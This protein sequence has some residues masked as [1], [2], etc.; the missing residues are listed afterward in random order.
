[1]KKLLAVFL[2]LILFSISSYSQT[3][4][5]SVH[6]ANG[7]VVHAAG[8]G[9]SYFISY[10]GGAN[11]GSYPQGSDNYN[12]VFA[13][14]SRVVL[15]GDGGVVRVSTNGGNSFT[16]YNL[17][18][19]DLNSVWFADDNTGWAVGNSGR[20]VKTVNGGVNW[21]LQTAPS[22]DN[23][24]GV[25]FTSTSNGYA[26]GDNG[27]VIYTVNGGTNWLSYT[28][29]SSFKLTAIDVNGS[30]IIATGVDSKILKYNGS[31][32]STIDYKIVTK[33]DVRGVSMINSTTF[34]TC[35]GGGFVNKTTDG[36]ATR[37]YQQNPMM[38][39]LSDIFFY[40][41]NTGWAVA[42]NTKAIIRTADGGATWQFQGGVTVNTNWVLKQTG[43]TGAGIGNGFCYHPTNR[44]GMFCMIGN[45]VYRSL[46]KGETWTTVGVDPPSP[47]T[48]NCHSFYVN[49]QDTNLWI[50]SK[51]SGGGY[52]IASSNYGASWYAVA[53]PLTLTSYGMPLEVD[54]NSPNTV[55]LAPDGA[56]MRIS[57]NWGAN[58]TNLSGGEPGGIFRSPCDI[59][60]QYENSN[61]IIVGDGTTGTGSGK[62]WKST[63][64]GINWTLINTVSG[65]EI[66]MIANS[67]VDL[68]LMYHSTWSTGSFWK[69]TN[70]GSN[71]F[72]T[73][74]GGIN[75][76]WAADVAKDDPNS[77][78]YGTYST[79]TW[80]STNGGVTFVAKSIGGGSGAG[81][82]YF[83]K[84]TLLFSQTNRG[85]Y[86]LDISYVVTPVTGV[87][88]TSGEIPNSF[89]LSQN[90]PNPFNPTTQIKFDVAKSSDVSI[91]VYDVIGNEVA[92]LTSG[93]HQ[94][95]KYTADFN[96]SNLATGIYFYSLIVDGAK[97][98]TKKMILVK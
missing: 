23:L 21:T 44:N 5:N 88:Q 26:C 50:A 51:G 62:V 57:T 3:G 64:G 36:G 28:T 56:A 58:W 2:G 31:I 95:G 78:A 43:A 18:G 25:R 45:T 89:M 52:V 7:T 63:N 74:N 40:D 60:V 47:W 4:F 65:S 80:F 66:P 32:W 15:V 24:N 34:Y 35:G 8:D 33:S 27:K 76:L 90:Y 9:G 1:M 55:Y 19:A 59:I 68:N 38:G 82:L 16:S 10:D 42:N 94:A 81:A 39:Y 79:S 54:P 67:S 37:V 48:G 12:G 75:S 71:F 73:G 91:K 92:V 53:G 83:D 14:N 6:S 96:A 17:G 69:S 22:A 70:T 29:G 13:I 20:I 46:D 11:F 30:T 61:V 87:Q 93:N 97:I 72:I 77:V 98:D 49:T 41:A 86:K 84:S 85:I